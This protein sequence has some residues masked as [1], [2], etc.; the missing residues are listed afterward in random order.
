MNRLNERYGDR[1][2]FVMLDVD[3]ESTLPLRQQYDIV[4]RSQYVLVNSEGVT[5]HRWFGHI[6]E[7]DL[8]RTLEADLAEY[9]AEA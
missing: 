8:A 2:D 5:V 9:L 3:E 7:N 6:S 1:I 4:A